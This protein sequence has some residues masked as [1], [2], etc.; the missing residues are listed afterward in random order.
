MPH[1]FQR[2]VAPIL[3]VLASLSLLSC[4]SGSSLLAALS[5]QPTPEYQVVVYGGTASGTIAAI[6]AARDGL[7]VAL[8]E[9]GNHIGGMLSGGLGATDYGNRLVIGGRALEFFQRAGGSYGRDTAWQFEPHVAEKTLR[10]WLDESGVKVFFG[11]HIVN[12]QKAD[13]KIASLETDDGKIFTAGVYIDASY[14]G[15]LM[16][17][18]GVSYTLG[19]ES[20]STYGETLAGRQQYCPNHQF[21]VPVPAY[22]S[23][24]Q[25]SPLVSLADSAQP[26]AGDRKIQAY[27]YRLCMTKNQD[28]QVPFP[29]PAGYDPKSYDLLQRYLSLQGGDLNLSGL[30]AL[31]S[32]PNGKTDTNNNG[33]IS[34]DFIGGSWDYPDA[35]F[36]R[37]EEIKEDHK[38]YLQGFL[39]FLAND[40]GVPAQLQSEMQQWGLAKDEFTD[41]GNWPHQIYVR[42]GRRMTGRYVMTQADLQTNLTKSDSIGMGS[43]D[44]DS[45]HVQ[46]YATPNGTVLNEGDVE[47]PVNPYQIPYSAIVPKESECENLAVTVCMSA[48]HVAFS[49]LRMEPQFMIMGQAAGQ[50]AYLAT[51]DGSTMQGVDVTQ[52]RSGLR[53]QQQVLEW[54]DVKLANTTPPVGSIQIDGGA[55]ETASAGATL[56]LLATS[57]V[58]TVTQMQFSNDSGASWSPWEAYSTSRELT[59]TPAVSGPK[60]VTVRYQDSWGNISNSYAATI[61]LILPQ[62]SGAVQINGGVPRTNSVA[63]VL[64]LSARSTVGSVAQMQFSKD[65]G[66]SWYPW[67]AYATTRDVTLVPAGDGIK[68]VSSASGMRRATC[69]PPTRPRSSSTLRRQREP[70]SSITELRPPPFQ[71]RC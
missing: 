44:S 37:R 3:A 33:P 52:L 25:L 30:L 51:R 17:M 40:P 60:S 63:A 70:Y 15:D 48:S 12:A 47:V 34:T 39:Y 4:S 5:T 53:A 46:R 18:A 10:D 68:S 29:K 58:H 54:S 62:L 1:M 31:N 41:T 69:R 56:T 65:G 35:D 23:A 49:S 32:V 28:N 43:Y 27:N 24:N 61:T 6:T 50:A 7:K 13:R 64:A 36:A 38:R 8:V 42:E 71:R 19:R 55:P 14:E 22:D 11:H 66:A 16:A 59:L 26:G 9:P 20:R 67:E 21:T 2:L 45:H 57:A